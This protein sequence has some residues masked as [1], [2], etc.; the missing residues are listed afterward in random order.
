MKAQRRRS[1]FPM[2]PP[3]GSL[4]SPMESRILLGLGFLLAGALWALAILSDG[5]GGLL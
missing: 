2:A 3:S 4:F 1:L 5:L